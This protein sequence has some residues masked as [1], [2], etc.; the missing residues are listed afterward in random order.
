M[1][2]A[3]EEVPPLGELLRNCLGL[4]HL[5]LQTTGWTRAE[6]RLVLAYV[7]GFFSMYSSTVGAS[8]AGAMNVNDEE[9]KGRKREERMGEDNLFRRRRRERRER[10]RR[11]WV[12]RID[13]D[14]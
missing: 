1:A 9:R 7:R 10:E 2:E 5:S 14:L 13:L 6:R 8:G 4:R 11:E 12:K 3:G